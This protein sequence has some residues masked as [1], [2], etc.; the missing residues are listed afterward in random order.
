[1]TNAPVE[2]FRCLTNGVYVIGVASGDRVNAFTAV[3]VTQ[4]SFDPLLLALNVH[5][6][7]FSYPLLKASGGFTVN[8]LAKSQLDLARHFGT[9]SGRDMDKLA[10]MRWRPGSSGA[11]VLLDALAW[12][13]CR[14]IGATPA[15]DHELQLARAV[16]G[17]VLTAGTPLRYADTGDLDGSAGLFPPKF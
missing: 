2:V 8:V 17:A 7:N 6:A 4:V 13:D 9:R 1:V 10:G 14:V 12:L 3:W 16:D 11:P 5:P 15:G